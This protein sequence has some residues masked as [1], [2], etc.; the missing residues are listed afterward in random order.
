MLDQRLVGV[1]VNPRVD[2]LVADRVALGVGRII[3]RSHCATCLHAQ[4]CADMA[5]RAPLGQISNHAAAQTLITI[6]EPLPWSG[7]WQSAALSA[8]WALYTPPGPR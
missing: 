2:S 5:G 6:Q 1:G 7:A 3:H 4:G 8:S